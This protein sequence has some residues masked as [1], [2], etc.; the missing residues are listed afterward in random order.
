LACDLAA[1]MGPDTNAGTDGSYQVRSMY[2]D[3]PDYMAYHEKWAGMSIRHKLRVRAYGN[4]LSVVRLEVKSRYINFIHKIAVD[5]PRAEYEEIERAIRS[6][7]LP[8]SRLMNMGNSRE[9]FRLQRQYNMEPKVIVEYRRQALERREINRIRVNFD[10]QLLT[11]RNLDL[12]GSL[13]GT[14]R[15]LAH[16]YGVFE[17]KVDGFM[18]YWMHML[19]AK[20]ELQAQALSKY[21]YAV[22]SEARISPLA[23]WDEL[24]N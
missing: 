9:F 16:G 22:R 15:V 21:V 2:F 7:T 14:R 13:K 23:R 24:V 10:D 11:T 18:P 6:R 12:F 20:Y 1:F 19:I 5:F 8:P 3:T 4:N 17:I